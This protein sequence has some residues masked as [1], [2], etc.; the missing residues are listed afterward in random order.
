MALSGTERVV[1]DGCVLGAGAAAAGWW[2]GRYGYDPV[3][4]VLWSMGALIL[5]V[6]VSR[7]GARRRPAAPGAVRAAPRIP[8]SEEVR[9]HAAR[10]LGT[11]SEA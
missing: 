8:A 10:Q 1:L 9:R 4:Y 2:A 11:G 7:G 5:L 6:A 3:A